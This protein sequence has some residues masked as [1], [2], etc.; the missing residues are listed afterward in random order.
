MTVSQWMAS[1][2]F[3]DADAHAL[4]EGCYGGNLAVT[5]KDVH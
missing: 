2:Q 5:E 3:D 4:A 1:Q